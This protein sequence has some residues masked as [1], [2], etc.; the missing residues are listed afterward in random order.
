ME[1]DD[2]AL[3][4]KYGSQDPELG[5]LMKEH[6]EFEARIEDLNKRPYLSPEE[7][8]ERKR[9][10]KQKLSGRDRIEQIVSEYRKREQG[11]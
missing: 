5:K 6:E 2:R 1:H 9:L 3:I 11:E 7:A 10:Q 8:L 4:E